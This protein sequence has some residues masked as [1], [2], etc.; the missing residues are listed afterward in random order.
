[1]GRW[2]D[3]HRVFEWPPPGTG[4]H[5][6]EKEEEGMASSSLEDGR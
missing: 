3:H 2:S 1:M 4:G 5:T 6:E